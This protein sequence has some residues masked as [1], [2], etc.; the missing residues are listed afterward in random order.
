MSNV[1][2]NT[3]IMDSINLGK[4]LKFKYPSSENRE[5]LRERII[6][7]YI[8]GMINVHNTS[9]LL[10]GY[11]HSEPPGFRSFYTENLEDPEILTEDMLE[12]EKPRKAQWHKIFSERIK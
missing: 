1:I 8:Y 5:I 7:P 6:S 4:K 12:P 11:Q 2:I 10:V 9:A 3:V